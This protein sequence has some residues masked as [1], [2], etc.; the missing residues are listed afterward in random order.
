MM[1]PTSLV[2]KKKPIPAGAQN[3]ETTGELTFNQ[4]AELVWFMPHMHLR[5]KDMTF[6]LVYPNGLKDTVLSAKFSFQWQLGYEVEEP[7]K[8]PRGTKMIV[9]AHYDNS[10]NNR[11]N[12]APEKEVRW[13][14]LTSDE[15]MLPWFGVVV[16]KDA[17][18]AMIASYT[19]GGATPSATPD[20]GFRLQTPPFAPVIPTTPTIGKKK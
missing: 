9:T 4:D 16:K 12:P 17:D 5:G 19:P 7:I 2:D 18:P 1:A 10:A 8:I 11:S 14:E 6:R 3:F 13:G 15:M 20:T